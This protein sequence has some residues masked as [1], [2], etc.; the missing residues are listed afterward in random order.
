MDG[1]V[2]TPVLGGGGESQCANGDRVA[3][4]AEGGE[5][6]SAE[7]GGSGSGASGGACSRVVFRVRSVKFDVRHEVGEAVLRPLWMWDAGRCVWRF[8]RRHGPVRRGSAL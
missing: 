2:A 5:H 3:K 7:G 4:Q 1:V 6:G 8:E